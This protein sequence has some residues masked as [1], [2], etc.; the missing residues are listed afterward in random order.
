MTCSG[1]DWMPWDLSELELLSHDA[2]IDVSAVIH[3]AGVAHRVASE[4]EYDQ[5]NVKGTAL[6]A[7]SAAMA[8]V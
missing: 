5:I 7:E 2:F 6:L 1:A 4:R 8:G 3:C